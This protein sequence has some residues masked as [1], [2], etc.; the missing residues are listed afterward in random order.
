MNPSE[1]LPALL[2]GLPVR[3][4]GPPDWPAADP[5]VALALQAAY[6]S[7]SWGKYHGGNVERL[8]QELAAYHDVP[9]ALTCGSGTFA[10]EVALRALKVGSADEVILAAY[11]YPGNFHCV[12]AVA[13]TPVLVDIDAENWNLAPAKLA[14]AVSPKTRA[15]IASHLHGGI[16]PMR[17]LCDFAAAHG[18]RVVE[19]AAQAT[20]AIIEGRRAGTWGDVGVLSFGGSKLL[21]AGRGGALLTR[22]DSVRQRARVLF[23]RGNHVCPMSELQAAVLI[24]QL[25]KLDGRNAHRTENVRRLGELLKDVPGLRLFTNGVVDSQPAYYKLGMQFDAA[26][27]GLSRELF[28]AAIRAEGMAMDEG[29]NALHV[30]RSPRRLCR[31]PELTEAERA[32]AGVVVLHHPVLLAAASDI[33]EIALALRKVYA[34][35]DLIAYQAGQRAE[36]R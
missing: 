22:D 11:D 14:R 33:E 1:T 18:L 17:E 32:H 26:R 16:V 24:P 28:L 5:H 8:E 29:F 20:G 34:N 35:A 10:V 13:A 25:G 4:Q 6:A 9:F 19:D 31:L 27:F 2:G 23:H 15:L 7:G 30:G 21:T 3:P 36:A 12:H